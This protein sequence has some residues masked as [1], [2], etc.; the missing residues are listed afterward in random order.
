MLRR[1]LS[2]PKKRRK[3]EL[4][5]FYNTKRLHDV[6]PHRSTK[7]RGGDYSS[8]DAS[9]N[10]AAFTSSMTCTPF[11]IT[12]SFQAAGKLAS[13]TLHDF[14]GVLSKFVATRPFTELIVLF[15][16]KVEDWHH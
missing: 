16:F 5:L 15:R 2:K 3:C 9:L 13:M 11:L 4:N 8:S 6:S 12:G 1:V 14:V 7:R 10:F